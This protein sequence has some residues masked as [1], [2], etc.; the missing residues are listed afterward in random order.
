[1]VY[2]GLSVDR[3]SYV[4]NYLNSNQF[5]VKFQLG[6]FGK[7]VDKTE[8]GMT[9]ATINAYYNPSYNEI[10]FPAAIM[11]SPFFDAKADDAVNYGAMGAVI[12]HELTH[13]FD[14]QGSMFDG[15]GNMKNWWSEQDRMNFENKTKMLVDQFNHFVVMDSLTVN[16]ELTLGENIADLGGL[17]IAYYA[18]QLAQEKSP[19]PK[20][21]DGFTPNQRFFISWAQAWRNSQRPKSLM[22]MVKTNPHSPARFRVIG[23]LSNMK[24]FYDAFDVKEGDQMWRKPDARVDI[25]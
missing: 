24:E 11:Q 9:P 5:D 10:V 21:I 8:W 6:K 16:G 15:D 25:W 12:G 19:Q 23:P 2:K 17:T 18:F 7:P 4:R 13:G 3:T 1:R 14:D 20:T 22:M